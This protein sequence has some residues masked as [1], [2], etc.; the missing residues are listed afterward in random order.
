[1]FFADLN[2]ALEPAWPWSLP[3]IGWPALLGVALALVAL[4]VWTYLGVK[5]ATWRRVS[6]VLVLRLMALLV[7]FSL[8]LRPSFAVTQLVGVDVTKLL[9]V[10]DNSESMNVADVESKPTRWEHLNKLWASRNVQRRLDDLRVEQKIEV[11]KYLGALEL[12]P[13]EPNAVADGK[14]TDIGAWLHQLREKHG[15]EKHLRGI[16][17]FSDGADNGARFSLQAEARDWRRIA[18]V[19]TFGVGNPNNARFKKDLVLTKLDVKPELIFVKSMMQI[20]AVAQAPGFKGTEFEGSVW[21]ENVRD[22]KSEKLADIPKFKIKDEKDQ[23]IA[24]SAAAPAELGEYKLTVKITPHPDEASDKNNEISTYVQVIK[25]KIKVLW[26]DRPR[27]YE[28]T[29]AIRD[30][31]APDQRFEVYYVEPPAEPKVGPGKFYGFDERDYDVIVIGDLSAKQFAMGDPKIFERINEMVTRKKAGLLM[32]GGSETFAKGGWRDQKPIMNLLPVDFAPLKA[33][34]STADVQVVPTPAGMN[35]KFL[36]L[37]AD[38]KKNTEMWTKEF[39]PL[40][41]LMPV[42]KVADGAEIFLQ[43]RSDNTPVLVATARGGRVAVFAGDSTAKSWRLTKDTVQAYTRFWKQLVYWL[44]EQEDNANQLWIKLPRRRMSTDPADRLSFTFGLRDRERRDVPGAT[45]TAKVV[46]PSGELPVQFVANGN[47]QQGTFHGAKEPG[48]YQLVIDGKAKDVKADAKARFLVVTDDIEMLRPA[49]EHETLKRIAADAE[50]RFHLATEEEL[51]RFL[52]ELQN[53][54]NREGRQRTTHW[55]DWNRIPPSDSLRD[56][57]SGL[58]SSFALLGF[59]L[60]V[61]LLGGEW[62]LR[63]LWGFV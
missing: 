18:A 56:Q 26:V 20:E 15:H 44:A 45:F 24:V 1:M 52:D 14:R 39:D 61:A 62:L 23:K 22:K 3:A 51:V 33:E 6:F 5:K 27:F 34:F 28:P 41:G 40:D 16:V 2:L 9:V 47:Y 63:R 37:H 58:W 10:F 36:Q 49:A 4:T 19:H 35:A 30:A 7:A 12:R 43:G 59:V 38:P 32:L 25:E 55:P 50:G 8:M 60:F 54:V 42:G 11:V 13:D 21:V 53:Q 17:I 31:L 46:G 57:M 48:E 29:F